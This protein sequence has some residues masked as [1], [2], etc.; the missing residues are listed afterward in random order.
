MVEL[1]SSSNVPKSTNIQFSLVKFQTASMVTS[2][3]SILAEHQDRKT[4]SLYYYDFW[5]GS[6]Q[7]SFFIGALYLKKNF[8]HNKKVSKFFLIYQPYNTCVYLDAIC[9]KDNF[10]NATFSRFCIHQKKKKK[11]KFVIFFKVIHRDN[12]F[13]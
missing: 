11:K 5:Q 6:S 2:P 7:W 10:K 4:P 1:K 13:F 12:N 8:G 9:R 3:P